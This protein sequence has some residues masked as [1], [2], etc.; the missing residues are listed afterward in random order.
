T[1]A[2]RL[3]PRSRWDPTTC[4]GLPR[5]RSPS[6]R[7]PCP[8][9]RTSSPP[10]TAATPTTP[11]ATT[12]PRSAA[13]RSWSARPRQ[14]WPSPCPRRP[15]QRLADWRRAAGGTQLPARACRVHGL[16]RRGRPARRHA[17]HHRRLQRRRRQRQQ[18]QL[19]PDRRRHDRG[20]RGPDKPGL[21][22]AP[23]GLDNGSP[24]GAA[25][26]VGPNYLPGPAASTVSI[27]AAALPVGTHVITAVYSGDAD[28]ASSN[29][30]TQI[31][32]DTIVVS[33]A[34]TSL[35]FTVPPP[36]S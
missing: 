32:G 30:F 9:A 19:H 8:S 28:N 2:R 4:Q 12:S 26:P 3:A 20:Q 17:R 36:A 6:S 35:A 7:P 27:V 34:P 31:G 15:R 18:Q 5:P 13:T 11:A 10:S 21:H 23:A 24:I 14:A 33:A 16:H 25:Q 29:N 22:R 1:T